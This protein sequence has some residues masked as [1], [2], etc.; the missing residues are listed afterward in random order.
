MDRRTILLL[1]NFD[2]KPLF[3][4][5]TPMIENPLELD[6]IINI[7]KNENGSAKIPNESS[8]TACILQAQK[9]D[10]DT[11]FVNTRSENRSDSH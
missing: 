10:N 4:S 9:H 5:G 1:N 8:E 2:Q 3:L 11:Q 6:T 7:L